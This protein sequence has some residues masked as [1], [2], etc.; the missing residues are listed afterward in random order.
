MAKK[1][2]RD[3]GPEGVTKALPTS[4]QMGDLNMK[5]GGSVAP[6]KKAS[7]VSPKKVAALAT[8]MSLARAR[9]AAGAG[10]GAPPMP[11]ASTAPAMPAA[12]GDSGAP[13]GMKKGG[14]MKKMKS[15]VKKLASGGTFRSSANGIAQRG[16]T[17]VAYP[18]MAKGGSMKG[19]K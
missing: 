8:L 16:K 4:K 7:G 3:F 12:G 17:R 10:A 11:A 2:T 6:P 14:N 18:A 1:M 9:G 19:C 5:K 15:T 13:M